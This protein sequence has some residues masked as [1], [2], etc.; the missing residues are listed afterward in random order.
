M[1]D[2]KEAP[3]SLH[4]SSAVAGACIA[5]AGITVGALV[6]S[7]PAAPEAIAQHHAAP[8]TA[9]ISALPLAAD[10][11]ALLVSRNGLYLTV[12]AAGNVSPLRIA[13]QSLRTIP[14]QDLVYAP[15]Q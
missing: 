15:R 9:S 12:D 1:A 10:Q 3:R 11:R 8:V 5:L 2:N 6:T 7:G 14:G 4:L 13:D